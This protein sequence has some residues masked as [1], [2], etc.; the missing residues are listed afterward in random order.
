MKTTVQR[1]IHLCLS[2]AL[3]IL[4]FS[5]QAFGVE[6]LGAAGMICP[7]SENT[8]LTEVN[9]R[10]F[11][12][13]G[14]TAVYEAVFEGATDPVV[15]FYWDQ[16]DDGVADPAELLSG[17]VRTGDTYTLSFEVAETMSGGRLLVLFHD[18]DCPE[19]T[20]HVST[21]YVPEIAVCGVS[22]LDPCTCLNNATAPGNGQFGEVV[23][24]TS[25]PGETWTVVTASGLYQSG[26]SVPP[27][28]G[29]AIA[30]GTPLPADPDV[31]SNYLLEGVHVD[32]LGYT[33]TA[34]NGTDTLSISNRCYYAHPQI[35][36]LDNYCENYPVFNLEVTAPPYIGTFTV[37]INGNPAT[38]FN[39]AALGDGI[40]EVAFTFAATPVNDT[41]QGCTL[42]DTVQVEVFDNYIG[43]LACTHVNVGIS[44]E[45]YAVITPDMIL[46]DDYGCYATF[47]VNIMGRTSDTLYC[48]DVGQSFM[49]LIT[50]PIRNNACW[51]TVRVEDKL[52]P[53]FVCEDVTVS[54]ATDF[55]SLPFDTFVEVSDNC[56]P[57]FNLV[58]LNQGPLDNP[59]CN[60]GYSARITRTYRATDRYGN[61]SLCTHTITFDRPVLSDVTPP[62]DTTLSCSSSQDISP[63]AL[64][65]PTVDSLELG[66]FC[67]LV[68]FY[69]DASFT[70]CPGS[71]M[72]KRMWTVLDFCTGEDTTFLQ[73]IN[74]ADNE[75]PVLVCPADQTVSTGTF[76][77]TASYTLPRP[78]V[79]DN[80]TPDG[81]ITLQYYVNGFPQIPGQTVVT[82]PL[83]ANIITIQATD[84]CYNS[85]LC[86]YTVV[87]EDRIVP[88]MA[89]GPI[90]VSLQQD[91][92]VLVTADSLENFYS[93]N[94]SLG[95]TLIGKME[96]P[97]V[98]G[99]SVTYTCDEIGANMLV[100]VVY[101]QSG[102]SNSCMLT[103]T[104]Q[105]KIPPVVVFCPADTLV[106][107][108]TSIDLS[109]F[110]QALFEDNCH[111][112]PDI[113]YSELFVAG[114]C[115]TGE[116]TRT[117]IATD[118]YLNSSVCV[119]SITLI[120]TIAPSL[121]CADDITLSLDENGEAELTQ[122]NAILSLSDAC[123]E[124]VTLV[125]V[126]TVYTCDDIGSNTATASATDA[127]GN[128][129]SCVINVTVVDDSAPVFAN[130][131]DRN[132][133]LSD[134]EVCDL[135]YYND[136]AWLGLTATDNCAGNI[137]LD[138]GDIDIISS[139]CQDVDN[140]ET[141]SATITFTATDAYSNT[142]TCTIEITLTNDVPPVFDNCVGDVTVSLGESGTVSIDWTDYA[143][144]S[145]PL[146]CDEVSSTLEV[147]ALGQFTFDCDDVSESP[148]IITVTATTCGSPSSSCV[149]SVTVQDD[150]APDIDCPGDVTVDCDEDYRDTDVTGFPVVIDNCD[151][152]ITFED[153]D[154]AGSCPQELT[155][156]RT[157]TITGNG[158]NMGVC[159]QQITVTDDEAPVF[160]CET[161][162]VTITLDED[163]EAVLDPDD[164]VSGLADNCS[165]DITLTASRTSF[166]CED[167][168]DPIT[169]T[170][171]VSDE[172]GNTGS[173]EIS[174]TVID[175]LAPVFDCPPA[176][177]IECGEDLGPLVTG[178]PTGASDNCSFTITF[179]D[180]AA[181]LLCCDAGEVVRTWLIT[182]ASGNTA[183]CEQ[184]ITIEDTT[185]P[186][187]SCIDAVTV[188]LTDQ[189]AFLDPLEL[190]TT[191]SQDNC[192]GSSDDGGVFFFLSQDLVSCAD[193]G[194]SILTLLAVDACGN[195]ASCAIAL[196]VIDI[197]TPVITCP[198]DVTVACDAD[199]LSVQGFT[200][201]FD[202]SNW[203]SNVTGN[204]STDDTEAPDSV[205]LNSANFDD[206]ADAGFY[207]TD[208]CIQVPADGTIVFS[209]SYT[210]EDL[211][212][213]FDPFGYILEGNFTEL[214]DPSGPAQQTG[215]ATVA[216]AA[217]EEF[218]FS[219][220]TLDGLT[221]AAATITFRFIFTD[222][223][224][225]VVD[226]N[227]LESMAYNDVFTAACCET[228]TIMRTWTATDVSGNT[229][230][231]IQSIEITDN[232]APVLDCVAS[233]TVSLDE[234]GEGT[235]T[236]AELIEDLQDNCCE[237]ITTGLSQSSFD[238]TDIGSPVLVELTV[239]DACSNSTGCIVSVTVVDELAPVFAN[240][241]DAGFVLSATEAC[242]PASYA[243]P[244]LY[245]LTATDNCSG[246]V[247]ISAGIVT[248][249]VLFC[250]DTDSPG[251][252]SAT[253][254][255]TAT[256]A[257]DN[258]AICTIAVTVTNDTDPV[259][260][261]CAGDITVELSG[262]GS[263]TVQIEDLA[264][265]EMPFACT[266]LENSISY[267]VDRSLTFTCSDVP[268]SPVT[269]TIVASLCDG[270]NS[271]CTVNVTVLDVTAPV[272]ACPSDITLS[273]EEDESDLSLSGEP[274]LADAC[275]EA[276]FSYT[277]AF[278]PGTCN[279]EG[280]ITRTFTATDEYG[281]TG[282]CVQIITVVDTTAPVVVCENIT[283]YLDENGDANWTTEDVLGSASD[284]CS[285]ASLVTIFSYTL[286]CPGDDNVRFVPVTVT[287]EC[288]NTASC[289]ATVTIIDD[290]AP[291]FTCPADTI[292]D[293]GQSIA[294][295]NTGQ[296]L[297]AE[298]NC[299]S[300][301][302]TV[303]FS[304][305]FD[306]DCCASGVIT[307]T[308]TAQDVAGNTT[309][310]VQTI[311]VT[312]TLP[313]AI[314]CVE[315]TTVALEE[316]GTYE[317][318]VVDD[319]I[320]SL[321]DACCETIVVSP[322]TLTYTCDDL[323]NH[324]VEIS[325]TDA[326]GNSASCQVN[327]NV[328]NGETPD[329]QC[330]DDITLQAGPDCSASLSLVQ[331][332]GFTPVVTFNCDFTVSVERSDALAIADAYPLGAT[333]VTWTI[334][335][336]DGQVFYCTATVTVED[337]TAPVFTGCADVTFDLSVIG[338]CTPDAADLG[339]GFSDNC[340]A[341]LV[342][343]TLIIEDRDFCTGPEQGTRVIRYTFSATD[344]SDNEGSCS[345]TVTIVN[346]I[347]PVFTICR[348][349]ILE[350]GAGGV[351]SVDLDELAL[352]VLNAPCAI[353][354]TYDLG[355]V[356]T[357]DCED[358]GVHNYTVTAATCGAG[359][360]V[361]A[362]TVT[363]QQTDE[364]ELT[365]PADATINCTG[366]LDDF[367]ETYLAN[368][369][370]MGACL[371]DT[372]L[373]VT[374][375][376]DDCGQGTILFTFTAID[377]GGQSAVCTS[378]VTIVPDP[379]N[380]LTETDIDFPADITVNCQDISPA[381]AGAPIV[382]APACSNPEVSYTDTTVDPD[383][384]G[385]IVIERTW[386]V[387]DSCQDL[388]F[389]AVQ[390]I[391]R[392]IPGI[393]V[394]GPAS[395]VLAFAADDEC[396]T[397]V[398]L[399]PVAGSGCATDI[400]VVNDF[401]SGGADAS[402]FYPVG[403]TVVTYTLSNSC[404]ETN[405]YSV[406]VIVQ[407]INVPVVTCGPNIT[408]NCNADLDQIISDFPFAAADNCPETLALDTT[409]TFNLN[410]CGTGNVRLVF[411]ATDEGN[412]TG[413]CTRTITVQPDAGH[414][415]ET[416]DVD[417]P[418]DISLSCGSDTDPSA[419]GEPVVIAPSGC[420]SYVTTF[421]DEVFAGDPAGC[422]RIE[423]TWT[424]TDT[425]SGQSV[426][427]VQ[428]IQ[429]SA[430][431]PVILSAAADVTVSAPIDAC[432]T[433]VFLDTIVYAACAADITVTNDFNPA[434]GGNAS[435]VYEV[436][437]TV[438]TYTLT[439]ACGNTATHQVSV[440]VE[441]VTPPAVSCPDAVTVL[442]TDDLGAVVAGLDFTATDAC[443]LST[444]TR[445]LSDI[446]IDCGIGTA[447]ITFIAEDIHGLVSSCTTNIVIE[448]V[449]V[450]ESMIEWPADIT[451]SCSETSDE[452]ITG[453]PQFEENCS[454][455]E[456]TYED[457]APV[458]SGNGCEVIF[459][460]W[461]V[462]DNCVYEDE[463]E[464][465]FTYTQ[466]IYLPDYTGIEALD[467][468]FQLVHE[469]APADSCAAY[470]TLVFPVTTDFCA[471]DVT[472]A[473]DFNGG[474]ADASGFYPE[475]TT[476]V[477]YTIANGCET[478]F[479]DTAVVIVDDLNSPVVNCGP[480][481]RTVT[482]ATDIDSLIQ[483]W[484]ITILEPCPYEEI[485]EIN[486]NVS[487]CG[488]GT[489]NFNIRYVDIGDNEA[490]CNRVIIVT[491]GPEAFDED[492]IIWPDPEI[493]V[494]GGC[495]GAISPDDLDSYPVLEENY[496]CLDPI[497]VYEDEEIVPPVFS[498]NC[499]EV[500][501]TW[502]A[503]SSCNGDTLAVFEQMIG[504][505]FGGSPIIVMGDVMTEL[506]TGLG[507]V[508]I[509]L[510]SDRRSAFG[511]T[512][513]SGHYEVNAYDPGRGLTVLPSLAGDPAEGVT[514]G[515]LWAINRHI[516]GVEPLG[517]PY[518]I[519]AAD[520]DR[521]GSI[522]AVDIDLL[523]RRIL[524]TAPESTESSWRFVDAAYR[525]RNPVQ[526]LAE[527][528]PEAV[529]VYGPGDWHNA[530]FIGVKLG[531]V[532]NT[533]EEVI[534]G[535]SLRPDHELYTAARPLTAGHTYEVPVYMT[536]ASDVAGY[537][538]TISVDRN[539]ARI[540]ELIPGSL[541]RDVHINMSRAG[542]GL[543]SFVWDRTDRNL[544]MD[545]PIFRLRI[546]ALA[547]GQLEECLQ[548]NSELTMADLYTGNGES[549]KPVLRFH[550]AAMQAAASF[551]LYQNEP[552]PFEHETTIR[553]DIPAADEVTC[554]IYD[555]SGRIVWSAKRQLP[556]GR[557][558]LRL[559][560]RELGQA[561][562]VLF[563]R[564]ETGNY[565]A[566]KKMIVPMH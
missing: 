230:S 234:D 190:I 275:T 202:L 323:G 81:D 329:I 565:S 452:G 559:L 93:D 36:L 242:D 211:L 394:T 407:D 403:T 566:T 419:T 328:A 257:Y 385:C 162:P 485:L 542:E 150:L 308:W 143:S 74:I 408:V 216:V 420:A 459:R 243:D 460:T 76:T 286:N 180:L 285:E 395:P 6:R 500:L 541:M 209:W 345:M 356:L 100:V 186:T 123:C 348:D 295:V 515:D 220:Q 379:D 396:G 316:D 253:V 448:P 39:A 447:L 28:P 168:E 14:E 390:Q 324:Q 264:V 172:C 249:E 116:Y 153:V 124:T 254:T 392:P 517:S 135:D 415:F 268:V 262:D 198:D 138:E 306:A 102:N 182:D 16:D 405:T 157:F 174:V 80:C 406:T 256:D 438:V 55:Y 144:A 351:V 506:R 382:N 336:N 260:T 64:G 489:I 487:D 19:E 12:C 42:S 443:D 322:L 331:L 357:F 364:F 237:D 288:D 178:Q 18:T 40:H 175:D 258:E 482:C 277:D 199:L 225:P 537:Q 265:A 352:A 458:L 371:A 437:T 481:S 384:D 563:Y 462:I 87:V 26:A 108:M 155:I 111:P 411:S 474:G 524:G 67:E 397:D 65:Y 435:G 342:L 191:A 531:D 509:E 486:Y 533:I 232:T 417:F 9:G 467:E 210:S 31:P 525:F 22:I 145:Y 201:D 236:A 389:S 203:A 391:I 224:V 516:S 47:D 44:A 330:P 523:R 534:R 434:G 57:G 267:T 132:I 305:S 165:T 49:V 294:P 350:V 315:N 365:C 311:T 299:A 493:V 538:F 344:A 170:F 148:H 3:G 296:V 245:G 413:R 228:G 218:C 529:T 212:P 1:I 422:D 361:C 450:E 418:A 369:E 110:G 188:E 428:Q 27:L 445:I 52:A 261:T 181:D 96:S 129:S 117:W 320:I 173:C 154:V 518:K 490:Q 75:A 88:N 207:T 68:A 375:I 545:E 510:D 544:V 453:I 73:V 208:L 222:T 233:V 514:V 473:N 101:D 546:E 266:D 463:E 274:V 386:V 125:F 469:S 94:C 363:V 195:E 399:G 508:H 71:R 511:A 431:V 133:L 23:L 134:S 86:T 471:A 393:R 146:D 539:M 149:I 272:L 449:Y 551:E 247:S 536:A 83:G 159:V 61:A 221:G 69:T 103:V 303:G 380:A 346:D 479:R 106:D 10:T 426:S 78:D 66:F 231:C 85:S 355:P 519:I 530:S 142:A 21:D 310:C 354:V 121:V 504:V 152:D 332:A 367:Y 241:T 46:T 564:V 547:S 527:A 466:A 141:A 383:L 498:A 45:G 287:D 248:D 34:T 440:T 82:L 51:G 334:T 115:N 238:C 185:P 475:G 84:R 269:V 25:L 338:D 412:N 32:A 556:A 95:D 353:P 444:T 427:S 30:A 432:E 59:N 166:D 501:R 313:P 293:C 90:T 409:V 104:V 318:D 526:P 436:G 507:G 402:G 543:I 62:A 433:F 404:G 70:T 484:G 251:T 468:T 89:C 156:T 496:L 239:T 341:S 151:F 499:R 550:D 35:N 246:P 347:A 41:L 77:C 235:I 48:S 414:E 244:V 387:A 560:R 139:F 167:I 400:V 118:A 273:C 158:G 548:L 326:C 109:D 424:V 107:C 184:S 290:T 58:L 401:N 200:G 349:T 309:T 263:V 512:D 388:S 292:I 206:E 223:G 282:T 147:E 373:A 280:T 465:I 53:V 99:N 276:D 561:H 114:C 179:D 20:L 5:T 483:N 312:D 562:G 339:I 535:R 488:A 343:N 505:R 43:G 163:G 130:C 480:V 105:D 362:F 425:C 171:T 321:S 161:A 38:Q 300:L 137:P 79:S 430:P 29:D 378:V 127:C 513:R 455:L 92:A 128:F 358:V 372:T 495:P 476:I 113:A 15:S 439:N 193:A 410:G 302:L 446:D 164:Y 215:V 333:T 279:G 17:A 301:G 502:Y 259:F 461:T 8:S 72:I 429:V 56:D 398:S 205:T 451:L 140:P 91:G 381:V 7:D 327:I 477:V 314:V 503:I 271:A 98:L 240:C 213:V 359:T 11:Y 131:T 441:D 119:Q 491:G 250:E 50:D 366:D 553:F 255:F 160:V 229:A 360:A 227:C 2:A 122:D 204:G 197:V 97:L 317:I 464:G 319:L 189:V 492:D 214:T 194:E 307:R 217:G 552:N 532:N 136:A 555:L 370:A 283:V 454:D 497:F 192:C 376:L 196:T 284:L 291:T 470:V 187:L 298:D 423:R 416:E 421:E 325:A 528:F 281:N 442:C 520:A 63:E 457:E 270:R 176:A 177:T 24:V 304:D 126:P 478:L 340:D 169:V 226:D 521:S 37:T 374:E 252:L 112:D 13:A 33:L 554:T 278:L 297:D 494:F 377:L 472:I 120:D 289:I 4:C 219:Q 54:C 337:V 456:V 557:N 60:P 540:A 183:Q 522:D 549:R 558:E 368:F 335:L